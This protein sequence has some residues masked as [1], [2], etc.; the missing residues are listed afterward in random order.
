MQHSMEVRDRLATSGDLPLAEPLNVAETAL[1]LGFLSELALKTLYYSA[2][3]SAG[4][5][6]TT[7]ALSMPVMQEVMAFLTRDGLA[8]IIPGEGQGPASYRYRL[9]GRG[10]E[11]ANDA[12]ERNAYVGP[13]PVPL[14][15][16]II[17]PTGR[18]SPAVASHPRPSPPHSNSSS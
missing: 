17:R 16:Y 10:L 15:D 8:E 2:R 13:T 4:D 9:T 12:F 6:S 11:R 1:D 18:L 7:L 14:A 5:L 3:P